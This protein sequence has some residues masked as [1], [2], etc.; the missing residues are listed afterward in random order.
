MGLARA[1]QT[2]LPGSKAL[3]A[4]ERPQRCPQR[5]HQHQPSHT[6]PP[7]GPGQGHSAHPTA[8]VRGKEQGTEEVPPREALVSLGESQRSLAKASALG[9]G[10]GDT[11]VVV[12]EL[13]A[14]SHPVGGGALGP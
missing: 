2:C 8:G 11:V 12:T 10:L 14:R 5:C 7:S 6:R 13:L 4:F 3:P 1:V 9:E